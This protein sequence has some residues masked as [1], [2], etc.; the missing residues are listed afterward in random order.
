MAIPTIIKRKAGQTKIPINPLKKASIIC[1][2]QPD[3]KKRSELY[4]VSTPGFVTKLT[5]RC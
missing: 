1:V 3:P 2:S 5:I 4:D